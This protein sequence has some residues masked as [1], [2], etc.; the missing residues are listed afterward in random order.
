MAYAFEQFAVMSVSYVQHTL[1]FFINS[2]VQCG[3]RNIE[4]WGGTPHYCRLD[5]TSDTEAKIA[6]TDIKHQFDNAGL[7]VVMYTPETLN[8]PFS[9]SS[10]NPLTRCRT[11]A[12]MKDA[13]CDAKILGTH[14]IF[15]NSGCAPRDIDRENSWQHLVKSI[16]EV[17]TYAESQGTELVIEQL[18]PYESNLITTL[19]DIQRILSDVNSSAL[20]VCVDVV[21][22]RVADES[23]EDYFSTFGDAIAHI[24]F[25]D[26]CHYVLGDG[27]YPLSEFLNTLEKYKYRGH[28]TLEINDAIYWLDPHDAMQRTV[29]Y[30]KELLEHQTK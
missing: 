6:L 23:L 19:P 20:K 5:Y 26:T 9:Y 12:F 28:L 2:M 1:D 21:A 11:I 27:D 15:L 3:F 8:Y 30:L 13:I 25:S 24:H 16:K 14:R 7:K 22:M 18:Q 29:D 4:F 10:P 17:A